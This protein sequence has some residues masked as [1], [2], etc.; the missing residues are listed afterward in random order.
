MVKSYFRYL[1]QSFFGVVSSGKCIYILKGKY[2]V[3]AANEHAI[4]WNLKEKKKVC[5]YLGK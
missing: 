2:I 5:V 1:L 4:V 3:S